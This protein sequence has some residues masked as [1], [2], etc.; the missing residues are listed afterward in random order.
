M[1]IHFLFHSVGSPPESEYGRCGQQTW[2]QRFS[3]MCVCKLLCVHVS[4]LP[5]TDVP[6]DDESYSSS[7]SGS[8]DYYQYSRGRRGTFITNVNNKWCV[9]I[10]KEARLSMKDSQYENYREILKS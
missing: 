8:G 3:V 9:I 1:N 6:V 4:V 7:G 10:K 2:C 5:N